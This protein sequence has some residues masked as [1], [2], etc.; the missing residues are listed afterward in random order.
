MSK[1]DLVPVFYD[2]QNRNG[3]PAYHETRENIKK[4]RK[5]GNLHGSYQQNGAIFILYQR[6]AKEF[7]HLEFAAGHSFSSAWNIRQ[8]G[9]AGPLVWQMKSTRIAV[10]TK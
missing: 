1:H 7:N 5:S 2:G 4:Q 9:Y 10:P 8:S 3:K 6:I